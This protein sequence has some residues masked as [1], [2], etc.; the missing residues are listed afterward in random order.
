[1][2]IKLEHN[3]LETAKDILTMQTA[4]YKVKLQSVGVFFTPH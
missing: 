4:A 3:L 1:M 2:I